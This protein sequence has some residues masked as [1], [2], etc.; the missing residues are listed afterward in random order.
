MFAVATPPS[1]AF[2][3]ITWN[4]DSWTFC[5]NLHAFVRSLWL[6]VRKLA[7]GHLLFLPLV[8]REVPFPVIAWP[9]IL[10]H[11]NSRPVAYY[12]DGGTTPHLR[13]VSIWEAQLL[14]GFH[15]VTRYTHVH[16]VPHA[17]HMESSKWRWSKHDQD[18]TVPQHNVHRSIMSVTWCQT[19]TTLPKPVYF[20]CK[21][22]TDRHTYKHNL[23]L[24]SY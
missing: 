19:G 20:N 14:V 4:R 1:S 16:H 15:S 3:D 11:L 13:L 8:F 10:V 22:I 5:P 17:E 21:L 7:G 18:D 12:K 6:F 9:Q 2:A 24:R 23:T